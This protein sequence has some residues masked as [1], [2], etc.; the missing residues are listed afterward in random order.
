MKKMFSMKSSLS[1]LAFLTSALGFVAGCSDYLEDFQEKYDDGKAFN[2]PSNEDDNGTS[3]AQDAGDAPSSSS[4]EASSGTSNA[5]TEES[6]E[7][8]GSSNSNGFS[9]SSSST[10]AESSNSHFKSKTVDDCNT[11]TVIYDDN[12]SNKPLKIGDL[13]DKDKLEGGSYL[14]NHDFSMDSNTLRLFLD[15]A[16]DH[17]VK[18]DLSGWG[19]LCIEYTST[20][21]MGIHFYSAPNAL[22]INQ[23][24]DAVAAFESSN[25]KK[26]AKTFEWKDLEAE[27]V[28]DSTN[29]I[30]FYR[31]AS[32][33]GSIKIHKI[34]TFNSSVNN[35][36]V[37]VT[38]ESSSEN[39]SSSSNSITCDGTVLWGS[40][41]IL[42]G[43]GLITGSDAAATSSNTGGNMF[44]YLSPAV[45]TQP[46]P[47]DDLIPDAFNIL[48]WGGLCVEYKSDYHL[49][50]EVSNATYNASDNSNVIGGKFDTDASPNEIKKAEISWEAMFTSSDSKKVL[51]AARRIKFFTNA[52][53]NSRYTI[54]KIT[55]YHKNVAL[56]SPH[57]AKGTCNGS[58][59]FSNGSI[60][61]KK[62]PSRTSTP[63]QD[64][65]YIEY[66]KDTLILKSTV[67]DSDKIYM[68]FATGELEF[69][70]LGGICLEYES[71]YPVDVYPTLGLIS[72]IEDSSH[73]RIPRTEGTD[74][75]NGYQSLWIPASAFIGSPENVNTLVFKFPRTQGNVSYE[76]K[77]K[78]VTAYKSGINL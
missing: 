11:G 4:Q 16:A 63:G 29:I 26:V 23:G 36:L 49:N 50:I 54:N 58:D 10:D 32:D 40:E 69:E 78:K 19:G 59:I 24:T 31:Y 17:S 75:Y 60:I 70:R 37:Q 71:D 34:T 27:S 45:I 22:A 41:S 77:I 3:N 44:L 20:T 67:A 55:T 76:I 5:D 1:K 61:N 28:I 33:N 74:N 2:N 7:S 47:K 14:Q 38:T 51:D 43:T 8:N 65:S 35:L 15:D 21:H 9:S 68:P 56:T 72:D 57:F 62:F 39:P 12:N 52:G 48:S 73:V 6:S 30:D 64:K 53:D 25:N 13:F 42:V 66:T 46:F 18:Y